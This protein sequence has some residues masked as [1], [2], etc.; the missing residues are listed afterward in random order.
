MKDDPSHSLS[1]KTMSSLL[2]QL[3]FTYILYLLVSNS[4][5]HSDHATRFPSSPPVKPRSAEFV[6][7]L[8]KCFRTTCTGSTCTS[9]HTVDW[10][11]GYMQ[12][13]LVER[14]AQVSLAGTY[15]AVRTLLKVWSLCHTA[16]LSMQDLVLR[17]LAAHTATP[18]KPPPSTSAKVQEPL[19]ATAQKIFDR[20]QLANSA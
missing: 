15:T 20:S 19:C 5:F 13:R 14:F 17:K 6:L 2:G 10:I 9:E 3:T 1:L 12:R 4:H 7:S 8:H 16:A 11:S 18:P